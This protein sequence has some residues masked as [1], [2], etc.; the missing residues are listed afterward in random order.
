M[1]K[2]IEADPF[3]KQIGA[4]LLVESILYGL[5]NAE[6]I[7]TQISSVLNFNGGDIQ[8]RTL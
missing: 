6:H 5:V 4:P 8:N 2:T 1:P 7:I 3:V